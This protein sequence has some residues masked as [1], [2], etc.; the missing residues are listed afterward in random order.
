MSA[1]WDSFVPGPQVWREVFRVLKPGGHAV[2]FAGTRTVDLMGISVRLAGF[3]V[4][5]VIHWC[6]WSGFPKSLDISKALD[7]L[8]GAERT[9]VIG[10]G[11]HYGTNGAE[12]HT[13]GRRA[14][15]VPG[16]AAT[17]RDLLAPA[18]EDAKRWAGHGTAVKPAIEP[19]LLLRKPISETSIARNVLKWGT[20][21]LNIDA[22]RFAPGDPM[23]PG[24][25][26]GEN[27]LARVPA[28]VADT[29]AGFGKGQAMGGRGHDLGRF[30]ANLV[31]V[32]KASRAERELGCEGLPTRTG[33][34]VT[35]RA[36]GSPGLDNPRSGAQRSHGV[37]NFHP[38]VKPLG[39]M[40]WLV[41]LVTPPGGVVLDPFA[42]S[43]TTGMAA[44]GQGFSFVGCELLAE[45]VQ[46]ARARIEYA[47]TGQTVDCDLADSRTPPTQ[48][49]MF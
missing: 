33:A 29:P 25:D 30:P 6:Y 9:E 47:G 40:R 20:G 21:S 17:G 14:D 18:T 3:E 19:A 41:R 12:G 46:I 34:E 24:P 35:G 10:K 37:R 15:Y 39:L 23:W 32:P 7:A 48:P 1:A 31:H 42:G 28:V 43:G 27:N 16:S 49:S 4:R 45:H 13:M 22:C 11:W 8:H 2:V 36:E 5:D 38:T 26:D 44:V